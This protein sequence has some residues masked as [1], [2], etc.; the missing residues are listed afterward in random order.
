[1]LTTILTNLIDELLINFWKSLLIVCLH[2]NVFTPCHVRI[3]MYYCMM[4]C[5][6]EIVN[7]RHSNEWTNSKRLP[8]L[9]EGISDICKI[10]I[11]STY[12]CFVQPMQAIVGPTLGNGWS[13]WQH[14]IVGVP[15]LAQ[16]WTNTQVSTVEVLLLAQRW[17]FN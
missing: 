17:N 11:S 9:C 12:Y 3:F 15:T 5:S 6:A 4:V 2:A 13:C 16:H 7:D 1:M 8:F 10:V 14:V